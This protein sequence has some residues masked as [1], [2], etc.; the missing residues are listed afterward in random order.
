LNG[1]TARHFLPRALAVRGEAKRPKKEFRSS[2]RSSGSNEIKEPS[3]GAVSTLGKAQSI[4]SSLRNRFKKTF[5][6]SVPTLPPQQLDASKAYFGDGFFS[7][8]GNGGF[9]DYNVECMTNTS[10]L[11]FYAPAPEDQNTAE[12]FKRLSKVPRLNNSNLSLSSN[13]NSRVTSWTNSTHTGSVRESPLERKRLSVIQEDGSPYQPSSSAGTHLDGVSAFHRPMTGA[14][15]DGQRL[16]SALTKRMNRELAETER[17]ATI[18]QEMDD[19]AEGPKTSFDSRPSIRQVR[20]ESSVGISG[21]NHDHRDFSFNDNPW[22][23]R[24]ELTPQK[25]RENIERRKERLQEQEAQSTFFPYSGGEKPATMSPFRKHLDALRHPDDAS[26]Q[27]TPGGGNGQRALTKHPRFALSSESIYSTTTNGGANPDYE[28]RVFSDLSATVPDETP[29]EEEH[30]AIYPSAGIV[31]A[32]TENCVEQDRRPHAYQETSHGPFEVRPIERHSD[33]CERRGLTHF[34]EHAEI[35]NDQTSWFP[36]NVSDQSANRVSLASGAVSLYDRGQSLMTPTGLTNL[37][38][39]LS[40]PKRRF[41]LLHVKQGRRNDESVSNHNVSPIRSQ[42]G[43]LQDITSAETPPDNDTGKHGNKLAAFIRKISPQNL[44]NLSQDKQSGPTVPSHKQHRQKENRP[45]PSGPREMASTPR[46]TYLATRSGNSVSGASRND[47]LHKSESPTDM[48]K[49]TLSAR[50]S[51]PFDLN[52]PNFN[53]SSSTMHL[54]NREAGSIDTT[55][56]RVSIPNRSRDVRGPRGYGGLGSPPFTT[57][58]KPEEETALPHFPT[59]ETE[60]K[61]QGLVK[62]EL[63][64]GIG[65]KRMVS[66]F[67]KSRR[68]SRTSNKKSQEDNVELENTGPNANSPLFV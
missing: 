36:Q 41:P 33:P 27:H 11:S 7:D 56:A 51:R 44:V 25:V 8:R 4:S 18:Q 15:P 61:K 34:R 54:G 38:N 24:S 28:R 32:R 59:P 16:Y 57:P 47:H 66:N 14:V 60:V 65:S 21:L 10:H 22:Q 42:S 26:L 53:Q 50:L 45:S 68:T 48:N 1:E 43:L 9:D 63:T 52:T 37:S 46:A 58:E 5:T 17:L 35:E 29:E 49:S 62:N 23:E 20:S 6:K 19:D 30:V 12:D 31:N 55:D 39:Q 67:L 3:N 13:S 40:V 2:V 64:L